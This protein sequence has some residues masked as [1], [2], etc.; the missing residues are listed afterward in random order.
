MRIL[1]PVRC[2]ANCESIEAEVGLV[3]GSLASH[4]SSG[5]VENLV[6]AA[7]PVVPGGVVTRIR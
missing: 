3:A 4:R 6:Q 1:H 7:A 5:R 2:P